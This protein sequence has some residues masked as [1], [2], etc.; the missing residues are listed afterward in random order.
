MFRHL[1]ICNVTSLDSQHLL[2]NIFATNYISLTLH[3]NLLPQ[4]IYLKV[5]E[6]FPRL[7]K[8]GLK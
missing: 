6:R 2:A 7:S 4:L 5:Q 3:P 8:G 1:S